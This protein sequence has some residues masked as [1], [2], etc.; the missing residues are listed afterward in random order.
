MSEPQKLSSL[1]RD[2]IKELRRVRAGDLRPNPKNW[3]E[4]PETQRAALQG[5][6]SEIGYADALIARLLP[7]G[8]LELIDGHLRAET[9]PDLMVPVLVTD[10]SE[11]ESDKLLASLDPLA[12]MA[13]MNKGKLSSLI[14][15]IETE[16][17]A[18]K[19]MFDDLL[20]IAQPIP[21]DDEIPEPPESPVTKRG[22]LIILGQHR[23]FC[24]DSS[25]P[26]DVAL[27]L[28]GAV[29]FIM[30]TDPPY[31]V[32]YDPEWRHKAGL[33]KSDRTGVVKNDDKADWTGAWKLFPGRV[34]Y[35]WHGG[36]HSATVHQSLIAA[37]FHV[38]AQ[39][40]WVKPRMVISRG[41]YHWQHE[42]AFVA[43]R[44][45]EGSDRTCEETWYAVRKGASSEWEGGRKQTTVWEI[46]FKGEV[47]TL[48]GTQK[49]VEC[50]ARPIRNHGGGQDAVYD[51]FLG[52]GTTLI[53]AEHLGRQCY[54]MELDPRYCDV[55]VQRWENI[56]G[57][58][59]ARE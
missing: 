27:L 42:P 7:D 19:A 44:E 11:E 39:I 49:P 23:L 40:V 33:N 54:G 56:T 21:H 53:A 38:R 41:H 8:S 36:L 4:H 57:Q 16:S 52:S 34:A 51:P 59:A 1:A 17:D 31:G 3:R 58:K 43:G 48:H 12:A 14:A 28:G 37:G 24:G 35:V 10:L 13:E 22:D 20:G 18:L 45:P 50:M 26:G 30:V 15:G 6:L 9:T 29:P 2:R 46:G 55:I 5:V 32:E 25:D 47:K